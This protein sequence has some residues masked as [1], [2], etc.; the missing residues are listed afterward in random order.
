MRSLTS[1][2]LLTMMCFVG[3]FSTQAASA[4]SVNTQSI[5]IKE[6][7]PGGEYIVAIDG[8]EQRT[9]TADHA[10]R[11][12]ERD[13]ALDKLQRAQPLYELDISQLKHSLELAK[14]DTALA[15]TQA[16]LEHER[17]GRFNSMFDGEHNLRLQAEQLN[18]HGPVSKFF[19]TPYAQIGFKAVLPVLQTWLTAR[20]E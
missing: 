13:A 4:Q 2:V 20:R 12:A 15:D 19:E 16:R 14:R 8:V 6:K 1:M 17:A 9:L 5:S 7:L 3:V 10:R 11:I 18:R